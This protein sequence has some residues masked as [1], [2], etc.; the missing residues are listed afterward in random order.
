MNLVRRTPVPTRRFQF[1]QR[2]EASAACDEVRRRAIFNDADMIE[3]DYPVRFPGRGKSVRH[4][5]HRRA[6]L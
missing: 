3:Y 1:Q 4:T 6:A 5:Q 2:R